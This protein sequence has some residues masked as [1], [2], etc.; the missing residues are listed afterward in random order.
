MA[1]KSDP[2]R[3]RNF[4]SVLR[5]VFSNPGQSRKDVADAVGISAASVTSIALKLVEAKLLREASPVAA[6]QGR[7]RVPLHVDSTSH[8]VM[9]IHLGPRVTGVV[10]TGLDGIAHA[11]ALVP[12]SG[13][14]AEQTF[15]VVVAEATKL[16][17]EHAVGRHVLGTG[18]ATGGIVDRERGIIVENS[19][20]GWF[21]VHAVAQLAGR[22]PG[23][24][25]LDN[26][27]R[28]AAQHELLFG[29]GAQ[30]P[31]FVLMV[32]TS[33]LGA[34][35]VSDGVIRAGHS[36]HAGKIAHLRV[37]DGQFR[38]DC[39]R[40]GCLQTVATDEATVR[41][42]QVA[43]RQDVRSY[44]DID[45]LYDAGDEQIRAIVAERD[46]YVARAAAVLMDLLDPGLV[47]IA[48]TPAER[49]ETLAHVRRV[50][51]ARAGQGELAAQ[52][53][54]YSSDHEL[55]LSIFAASIMV[56]EVLERPLSVL[57]PLSY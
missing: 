11:S 36:Q 54:V 27:A 33:D 26:N 53:V 41:C 55:S 29:H 7:P 57:E 50:V 24:V 30:Q 40:Q 17:E 15:D 56:N 49:P 42:A 47:V 16:V 4:A 1:R 37:S 8:L 31:D 38:C 39:G 10:L 20:A 18:V 3:E 14:S 52:R 44:A 43:G 45:R 32:N 51:A 5:E 12:H 13:F 35:L 22:L 28:A 9:G 19:G 48:G 6:G 34:V 2:I 25:V 23:P 21:D 46:G